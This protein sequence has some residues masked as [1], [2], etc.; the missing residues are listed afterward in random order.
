MNVRSHRRTVGNRGTRCRR[1]CF[2]EHLE[3]RDLLA[4]VEGSS[5]STPDLVVDLHPL[6]GFEQKLD[7]QW[8]GSLV[9]SDG[10]VYFR[11]LHS[12]ARTPQVLFF[13]SMTRRLIPWLRSVPT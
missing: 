10:K 7:G 6:N 4:G 1:R 3:R 2:L 13:Y 5:N 8:Q 9:A 12:R 11:L